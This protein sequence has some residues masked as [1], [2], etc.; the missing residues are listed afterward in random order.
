MGWE[1]EVRGLEGNGRKERNEEERY[2]EMEE[3]LVVD[4]RGGE[5]LGEGGMWERGVMPGGGDM[6]Y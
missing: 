6:G 2:E 3:G 1:R 5:V 4:W